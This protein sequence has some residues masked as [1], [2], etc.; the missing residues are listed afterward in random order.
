M[1]QLIEQGMASEVKGTQCISYI[2]KDNDLF[3]LSEYKIIHNQ[4]TTFFVDSAKLTYNG[5]VKLTY[6]IEDCVSLKSIAP[7]LESYPFVTVLA[8]LLSN[9]IEVVNNGYLDVSDLNLELNRIYVNPNTLAVKL[10][11]L[12]VNSVTAFGTVM[13]RMPDLEQLRDNLARLISATPNLISSQTK[14]ICNWLSD[15]AISLEE[16]YRRVRG[17]APAGPIHSEAADPNNAVLTLTA[18][19]AP[20]RTEF[21]INKRYY[22]IGRNEAEVDGHVS[23]NPAVG[24]VHCKIIKTGNGFAVEDLDSRNGTF[25]NKVRITSNQQVPLKTGDVLRMA[26]SDF[27]VTI[28]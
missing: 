7:T 18:I 2:L 5:N 13:L 8:N 14:E 3:N 4:N 26:N 21:V 1:H 12:P 22:V 25:V 15:G 11:Y 19:N 20:T 27:S 28:K 10:I 16:V 9:V 6:F 17:S 23:F 24:R